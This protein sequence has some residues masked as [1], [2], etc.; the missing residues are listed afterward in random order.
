MSET[1]TGAE[2]EIAAAPADV[3]AVMFDPAREPEWIAAVKA[4]EIIDPA[5]RPGARVRRTGRIAG[6]D[7]S[8]TSEVS[9][10]HFPHVLALRIADAPTPGTIGY[11]IQRSAGG[12][13]ARAHGSATD[14]VPT[15]DDLR[16]LKDLVERG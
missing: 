4:V 14:L 10:V 3:A 12:S 8:W 5:L 6:R 13:T 15:L 2:I 16:R 1:I 7:A 11:Q 9:G